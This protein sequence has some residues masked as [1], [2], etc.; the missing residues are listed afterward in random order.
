MTI[1][2][3][4]HPSIRNPQQA[5]YGGMKKW[6]EGVGE[7]KKQARR[8]ALQ[9]WEERDI[10]RQ[11]ESRALSRILARNRT[12][13]FLQSREVQEAQQMFEQEQRQAQWDA[14]AEGQKRVD[15]LWNELK[16]PAVWNSLSM[17][18]TADFEKE[19]EKETELGE[20]WKNA[21]EAKREGMIWNKIIQDRLNSEAAEGN[22]IEATVLQQY[23][24]A[25]MAPWDE[26][27]ATQQSLSQRIYYGDQPPPEDDTFLD[28]LGALFESGRELGVN[29]MS[30][31]GQ[32]GMLREHADELPPPPKT[33]QPEV[34]AMGLP[35]NFETPELS[36]EGAKEALYWAFEPF[37]QF[38]MNLAEGVKARKALME[39]PEKYQ[40]YLQDRYED[41]YQN[42][43]PNASNLEKIKQDW[44]AKWKAVLPGGKTREWYEGQPWYTQ[45]IS[46]LPVWVAL[47]YL[48]I[49]ATAGRAALAETAVQGGVK[50][51]AA[52]VARTALAPVAGYEWAIGKGIQYGIKVPLKGVAKLTNQ[53]FDEALSGKMGFWLAQQGQRGE[54]ANKIVQWF[55]QKNKSWLHRKANE[56][57]S[58]R[59]AE[60]MAAKDPSRAA[61]QAADDIMEEVV[62]RLQAAQEAVMGKS[63]VPKG[64]TSAIEAVGA[65]KPVGAT[66][67]GATKAP[68][69][70]L[71]TVAP[72]QAPSVE[73]QATEGTKAAVAPKESVE[74]AVGKEGELWAPKERVEAIGAA[75]SKKLLA[76]DKGK[77][78]PQM[79]RFSQAMTGKTDLKDMTP[80]ELAFL[81]EAV[82]ALPEAKGGKPPKIPTTT[83][84]IT[85]KFA[86]K[87]PI[88][89]EIGILER[90][91][92]ARKVWGK[93]GLYHEVYEP[94]MLA[95]V[96]LGEA[97]EKNARELNEIRKLVTK[98]R[99]AVVFDAIEHPEV[100][101]DLSV[102]EE[103][104]V[105]WFKDKFDQWAIDLKLP[106]EKRRNNYI[107][108]IFEADMA[109]QLKEKHPLD[110]GL[111][112]ALDF[113]TPN[114]VFNPYIQQRLGQEV[115]LKR[116]PFAAYEAYSARALKQYYYE[117]ILTRI[118]AYEKF[119][120]PNAARA[121]RE[122]ST[123]MTGR[124]SPIDNEF[125]QSLKELATQVEK[126]PKGKPLADALRSGNVAGMAAY[127]W[128]GLHYLAW[129][130]LRPAS[131]IKN[132]SQHGLILA[133][134][135]GRHLA[136]GIV[137]R[138][139]QE[140]KE[141][142]RESVVLRGRK[143]GYLPGV[144][145]AFISKTVNFSHKIAM[146]FFRGADK[147]NVSDAFLAGYAEAKARGL[148]YAWRLKRG[149][150]VAEKTQYIYTKMGGPMWSQ[151]APGRVLT[152]LSSW[153]INWGEAT[154]DWAKGASSRVYADYA[155]ETGKKVEGEKSAVLNRQFLT[156][157]AL[158]GLLYGAERKTNVKAT[159]Y[160]GWTSIKTLSSLLSGDLPGLTWIGGIA[161]LAAGA[162]T[163]DEY[164]IKTGWRNINPLKTIAIIKQLIDI[165]SGDKDWLS[166]FVYLEN[167]KTK[168][169]E[170]DSALVSRWK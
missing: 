114:K 98:E 7:A 165:G 3:Y 59:M 43:D 160:S 60:K 135:G 13:N 94:T 164:L 131:A 125:N 44:I 100:K 109:Q 91:R 1:R 9:K 85:A 92:P 170:S 159:L 168:A 96:Q 62:P 80:E 19:V 118:K 61:Q 122:F 124:P 169:K 128:A 106:K 119:L 31:G 76:S 58:K 51:A 6:Y 38:G 103:K 137:L 108:H 143:L 110:P 22:T 162:V 48:G 15:T 11:Y 2:W 39:S 63:V 8:S 84:V 151:T 87:I 132:L 35:A 89:H 24:D 163:A 136:E 70:G 126:L 36:L 69:E 130:G 32:L 77:W 49:T 20:I 158:V 67:L 40:A 10:A 113:I 153:A 42:Y 120:P 95:E 134:V 141:A 152:V 99:K 139:T 140:G 148:P 41:F 93:I 146:A 78:K 82:E 79:R 57:M 88:L 52:T 54:N 147:Q 105:R 86:E 142:L 25:A 21:D 26:A 144:D 75:V 104:A 116:D 23:L 115:G 155:E 53:A 45:L 27:K 107:T 129:L 156:Y 138:A 150:E 127:Q 71:G 74:P 149:D 161:Q 12:K 117:P 101:H 14:Q 56:A 30:A 33:E 81:Q 102:E 123:R 68:V 55:L 167:S 154:V 17:K 133:E 4:E 97:R 46:E 66:D 157:M 29:E 145:E 47:G 166:L 50:G 83:T 111:L 34:A 72:K 65:A 73:K 37:R 121:L 28:R 112:R 90:V 16:T 18:A 64:P 5:D